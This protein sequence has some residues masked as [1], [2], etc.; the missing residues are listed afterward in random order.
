MKARLQDLARLLGTKEEDARKFQVQVS[1]LIVD[2]HFNGLKGILAIG[3][4]REYGL[5]VGVLV[6]T[7]HAIRALGIIPTVEEVA[8]RVEEYALRRFGGKF[9]S[10]GKTAAR[11][12]PNPNKGVV[13]RGR[14]T[15]VPGGLV[16]VGGKHSSRSRGAGKMA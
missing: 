5:P 10:F 12:K 8:S 9:R 6:N 3:N 4:P 16:G 13:Y 2:R 15:V 11:N 7:V 1:N 14:I